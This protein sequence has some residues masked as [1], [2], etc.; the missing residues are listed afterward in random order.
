M[1]IKLF[2]PLTGT[3]IV[4]NPP[5]ALGGFKVL[6]DYISH[7]LNSWVDYHFPNFEINEFISENGLASESVDVTI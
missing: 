5:I 6:P 2:R 7:F 4:V 1:K 3:F